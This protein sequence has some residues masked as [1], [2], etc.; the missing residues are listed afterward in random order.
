MARRQS[1]S[2]R[3]VRVNMKD[4]DVRTVPPEGDYPLRVAEAK[5]ELSSNKNEQIS[6]TFEITG[7]ESKGGKLYLHCPLLDNSLWKLASVLTAL[8]VKVPSDEMDIDLDDLEDRTMMGVVINEEYNKRPQAK[9][10]DWADIDE[11]K[12]DD[13]KKSKKGKKGKKSKD[14][15]PEEKPAKG[16]RGKK[17]KEPEP[18][19]KASKKDKGKKGKKAKVEPIYES[20]DIGEMNA[21]KLQK[22]IDKHEL[23]VDLDDYK[24]DRKKAGAV[25][26]A[27]EAAGLLKE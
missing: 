15:E 22:V 4:V 3:S 20:D 8:R 26:D 14:A 21:K 12:G 9:L 27:L 2:A 6:F 23:D 25:V 19:P 17:D 7:G 24:T 5:K 11:Y 1:K 10:V 18:E 16:K 13:D